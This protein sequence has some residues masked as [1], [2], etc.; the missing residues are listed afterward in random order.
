MIGIGLNLRLTPA[1]RDQAGQ[2]VADLAGLCGGEPPSRNRVAA[3]LVEALVEGLAVFERDGFAGFVDDYGRHD[4]LRDRPLALS[5]A[6][7]DLHGIGAGVDAR[8]ALCLRQDD[9]S[10][11][12]IDSAEV[13]VRGV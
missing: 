9:G 11:R 8:G 3:A 4:L 1:L 6:Q 7:G 10:K 13:T 5:G 12:W 2:P